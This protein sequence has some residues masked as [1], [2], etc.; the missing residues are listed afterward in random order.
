V[1]ADPE[2]EVVS[3]CAPNFLHR[4]FAVAAAA[5]G[6]P[7]WIEKPAGRDADE[8]AEI[9]AAARAAGVVTAVGF[10]YRHAPAVQRARSLITSGALGR[11]TN[12]TVSLLADYS[13]D[14]L[15]AR[16]WRFQRDRAGSGVLG[17]LLSHGSDLAAYL[18][19]P[20]TAVT[21]L[22]TT[23]IEDRPLPAGATVGHARGSVGGPTGPVENEDYAAVLARF[24][25]PGVVGFL[26]ASRVAVGP[27]AS[28]GFEVYGTEGSLRWDFERMNE[29]QVCL[30]LGG[31]THGYSTVLAQPGDGDFGRFQPGPGLPMGFDDLKTIEA[32]QFLTSVI[33]GE[34]LAPSIED[35]L[36]AAEVNRAAEASAR[37]GQWHGVS[38]KSSG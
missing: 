15:A 22:T 5:A 19:A 35:A 32:W 21:A 24:D 14:P 17:D 30:G 37:D 10:N 3:I 27:R 38:A 34:Q 1:L 7:F 25:A 18:V 33:T 16:T 9:A 29:L 6:K 28:Y 36:R 23:V 4:D 8:T 2:V 26:Q 20:I 11:V 31:Q 12:L 13:A